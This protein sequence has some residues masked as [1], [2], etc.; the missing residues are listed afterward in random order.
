LISKVRAVLDDAIALWPAAAQANAIRSRDFSACELLD[1]YA[2]RI[3]RLNPAINAVVTLDL[4]RA[5]R[6]AAAID[7]RVARAEPV[8]TLAGVPM[9]IKDAIEV[10]EMRSTSGA[11]ELSDHVPAHDAP[12]VALLRA[13]G[14]VV[15]GKTNLPAWCAADTET[16]NELFGTTNNPWDL[17]RSVGGSSGGS[18]AAVA[19]GLSGCDIGTDI[20]GSIRIPSHY[21]GVYGLKPSYGVVPQLG[22]L[23]H[24]GAGQTNTDLN[25]FGPIA[26]APID[27]E[28]LL[29]VVAQPEPEA[30]LAWSVRLPPPRRARVDEYRI[31]FWFDEPD[32]PIAND[33]GKI[34]RRAV[35]ALQGAGAHVEESHPD[36]SFAEQVDLWFALVAAAVAPGLPTEL[37][38]P[39]AGTHLQWLRNHDRRQELRQRWHAWFADHDALLCPVVLSTAP[40]HDLAG[41]PLDRTFAVDG[42]D[43]SLTFDV[44]RWCGLINVIGFPSCV[45][46]IGRTAGGL[47]VGMQ[48]VAP[49]LRDR[50][51]IHLA[52]CLEDILGGFEVPPL[53]Q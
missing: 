32:C 50:E 15:V 20:G 49:Y 7:A 47:P 22:Y 42:V 13:A 45:V 23:S 16:N 4:E 44:P 26:R 30:A 29:E 43:R 53:A 3:E 2:T 38:E 24:L 40:E 9:T 19:A 39:A 37:R 5:R 36:V 52:R 31:G 46:P 11:G 6:D 41:D 51:T 14:A 33:Y 10:A 8:G 35:D 1:C 17:N 12:V 28:L 27:L 48:I 34:L 21:C 18:A 25:V